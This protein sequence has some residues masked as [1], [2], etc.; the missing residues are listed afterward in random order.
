MSRLLRPV[1]V[2]ANTSD[3]LDLFDRVSEVFPLVGYSIS[4]EISTKF[5]LKLWLFV[6]EV[7]HSS[8]L[9]EEKGL[10]NLR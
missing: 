6:D 2:C 7:I 9:L 3:F 5:D 1:L 10:S 8:A 4:N